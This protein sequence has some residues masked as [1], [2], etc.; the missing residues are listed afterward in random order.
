MPKK[1]NQCHVE[2]SRWS[3]LQLRLNRCAGETSET[4]L[5]SI[6]IAQVTSEALEARENLR[7]PGNL[8]SS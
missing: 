1:S 8:R 4:H 6:A 3:Y 5:N 2:E 7:A